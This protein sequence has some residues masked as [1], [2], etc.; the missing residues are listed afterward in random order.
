MGCTLPACIGTETRGRRGEHSPFQST[1]DVAYSDFLRSRAALRGDTVCPLFG[2][3]VVMLLR[4]L[5]GV[6]GTR[7]SE[8]DLVALRREPRRFR[9]SA[10]QPSSAVEGRGGVGRENSRRATGS[11][12]LA[13]SS[14]TRWWGESDMRRSLERAVRASKFSCPPSTPSRVCR[15]LT[16]LRGLRYT[17]LPS[18]M[19][20]ES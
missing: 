10:F 1:L 17:S 8:V 12:M 11:S 6:A 13:V 16:M 9:S 7:L 5:R 15:L 18:G 3:P 20:A 4:P 14:A 2:M 19:A